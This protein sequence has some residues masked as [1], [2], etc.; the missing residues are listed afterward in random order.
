MEQK[1]KI[2]AEKEKVITMT[3]ITYSQLNVT[4]NNFEQLD[5][6]FNNQVVKIQQSVKQNK[7]KVVEYLVDNILNVVIELP[8]NIKKSTIN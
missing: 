5:T 1:D 3:I 8:E 2:D 7:E 6:E 4:K